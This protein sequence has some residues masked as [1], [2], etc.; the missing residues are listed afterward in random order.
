MSIKF[1]ATGDF[2][3]LL[4]EN[5]KYQR[6][7]VKLT[8]Q[9][10]KLERAHDGMAASAGKLKGTNADVEQHAS[11]LGSLTSSVAKVAASY[12]SWQAAIQVVGDALRYV[13]EETEKAKTS[14][15]GLQPA[16]GQLAQIATSADDLAKMSSE[17]DR[18]AAG[19]GIKRE[20]SRMAIADS[21]NLGI[22]DKSLESM[23]KYSDITA[24]TSQ[25]TLGGKMS[26]IFGRENV[27]AEE[28]VS[29]GLLASG[30]SAAQ[31]EELAKGIPS[32]AEG[33]RMAGATAEETLSLYSIF[34]GQFGTAQ[35]GAERIKALG[36]KIGK[37][38]QLRGLG[39]T[40]AMQRMATM[41]ED[42]LFGGEGTV[43]G[44]DTESRV[45]YET[46]K[47]EMPAFQ[48]MTGKVAAE[49][50]TMRA[51]GES[52]IEKQYRQKF[53]PSLARTA[54]GRE[55]VEQQIALEQNR[56]QEI[57]LEIANE[58]QLATGGVTRETARDTE[59]AR[60]KREGQSALYQFG[61]SRAAQAADLLGASAGMTETATSF[62]TQA[63]A[64]GVMGAAGL[65]DFWRRRL[66]GR[67]FGDSTPTA[68][69]GGFPPAAA[70]PGLVLPPGQESPIAAEQLEEAR[71]QRA[72]NERQAETLDRISDQ[73]GNAPR[74]GASAAAAG[75]NPQRQGR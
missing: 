22:D 36:A 68:T 63:A 72:I 19:Y 39:F 58:R 46:L 54:A 9:V 3:Q 1:E 8:E 56:R 55:Y 73:L 50:S 52:T 21:R 27:T 48:E 51:G 71:R 47:K 12:V 24:L 5:A 20:E 61:G 2:S 13:Q 59:L 57:A 62:G 49:K 6:A 7:L 14:L 25:T 64:V 32:A 60:Q 74:S 43:F 28:A 33:G 44:L 34:A 37:S 11:T 15:K 67:Y 66:M 41:R 69:S 16:E 29:M 18:L 17:A 31:F 42:E 10:E 45:A 4:A 40:K 30:G 23:A 26:M 70:P 75:P 65:V 38:E 53:D 35:T